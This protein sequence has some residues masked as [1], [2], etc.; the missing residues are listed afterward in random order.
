MVVTA[1]DKADQ[2][3][4]PAMILADGFLG[5]MMEPI[6]FPEIKSETVEKP[7]ATT[8][9]KGERKP[10]IVNS[11]YLDPQELENNNLALDKIYKEIDK[12][13]KSRIEVYE[14]EKKTEEFYTFA[15]SALLL[16]AIAFLL[17]T[18]VLKV[19]P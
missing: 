10:N 2:Y 8:G 16:L 6:A 13:E 18:L 1:F 11:L 3:R 19:F 12:M 9:T 17:R 15:I 14:F 5:Q 4:M 7:W